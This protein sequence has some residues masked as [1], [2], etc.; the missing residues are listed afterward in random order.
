[1]ISCFALANGRGKEVTKLNKRRKQ[2]PRK[3]GDSQMETSEKYWSDL[4]QR[5]KRENVSR[6]PESKFR[7][8]VWTREE[9][10]SQGD[11]KARKPLCQ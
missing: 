6:H 1:V 2:P 4:F 5:M 11:S 7:K 3:K 8:R 9:K 10:T